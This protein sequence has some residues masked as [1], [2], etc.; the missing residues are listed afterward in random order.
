MLISL[1]VILLLTISGIPLT[2]LVMRRET[3]LWRFA[4][5]NIVGASIYGTL[6]FILANFVG[7][8]ISLVIFT[9]IL[10]L[11]SLIIFANEEIRNAAHKEWESAKG[12]LHNTNLRRLLGIAFYLFFLVLFCAFFSRAMIET[13]DG[14]FTGADHNLGDLPFHLGGIYSFLYG[15]NFPPQNPSFAGAKFTYSF[16]SDFLTA[17]K[18]TLGSRVSTAMFIENVSW[19]F[20]LLI[21][22]ERFTNRFTM[23]RLAGKIAPTILLFSGGL[24]FLVL[25]QLYVQGNESLHILLMNIPRDFTIGNN[26]RW[27]NSMT[28]LFVTQRSLLLGLPLT[29][30]VI[31]AIWN[32]YSN[33][34]ERL[35]GEPK[36]M[37][38]LL[39]G[40]IAGLL[41]LIHVHS[42]MA[43]F[44]ISGF[45]F[46]ASIREWKAWLLFGAGVIIV[47]LPELS[48]TLAGS[49]SNTS[50]FIGFHYGWDSRGEMLALFWVKNTGLFIPLIFAG[51]FLGWYRIGGEGFKKHAVFLLPFLFI[52]TLANAF[53][54]APWEWDNIKLLI[55]WFIG[56][57]PFVAL[58]IALMWQKGA[59]YRLLAVF[60]LFVLIGAGMIDVWRQA[61]AQIRNEVFSAGSVQIAN[62]IKEKTPPHSLFLNAPTF[63]SAV[64]LSG[65]LSFIRYTGHLGS[66]GI[67]YSERERD[68]ESIYSGAHNAD[69]LLLKHNIN[70]ILVS[71]RERDLLE[72]NDDYLSKFRVVAERG[73][74]KFY[75]VK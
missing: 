51:L 14:I 70:F 68:T 9:H 8:T 10:L 13:A 29:L 30:L 22:L 48:W 21:I 23:N 17:A 33:D 36:F 66:Y 71:P 19:A 67:D 45:L 56:S 73:D 35:K 16:I 12:K 3:M 72:V 59:F 44:V 6:T 2:Y 61:S 74:Y 27:G 5:G 63:N 50:E 58:F 69:Q 52:F 38:F 37:P 31:H 1:F 54:F 24:G 65:R 7:L 4:A 11:A 49:A 55:Y 41:P 28:V 62:D 42:L 64:V 25:A 57:L 39:T 20:S 60:L 26:L 43:L 15:D 32:W 18:A 53:K 34:F 47:A 46:F 40:L 75:F